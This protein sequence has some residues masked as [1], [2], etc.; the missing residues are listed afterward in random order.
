M[1]ILG[2]KKMGNINWNLFEYFITLAEIQN[3]TKAAEVLSITQPAL[4]KAMNNLESALGVPLFQKKG[5]GVEL[6]FYGKIFLDHL[7]IARDEIYLGEQKIQAL[8]S[9]T[10]GH[11]RIASLYTMGV[12]LIPYLIKDFNEENPDVTFSLQ[13]QPTRPMLQMLKN[14]EIDLCFCTDFTGFEEENSF[15]K[16]LVSI[17]DLYMLVP[18]N[19]PFAHKSKVDLIEFK[20]DK[21]IFFNNNTFF[22]KPAIKLMEQAG[23][24]PNIAYEANED[25]TVA[26]FVAAGLGVALIPP[27]IGIDHSKC[28]LIPIRYPIAQRSLCM[29][30]R[31]DNQMVPIVNKF[32]DFVIRWLPN[33]K[34]IT[35]VKLS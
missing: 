35:Q 6:N 33:H 18:A 29:A 30:W 24:K 15:M 5:R 32:R 13:Q 27:I 20:D 19:H 17:E 22:K 10:S 4:S 28:V 25:S 26:A 3:Y 31:K 14:N 8:V 1:H 16:T 23:F 7:Y 11:I 34:D 2:G 9:P 21:F 12:N